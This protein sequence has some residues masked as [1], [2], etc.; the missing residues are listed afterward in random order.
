MIFWKLCKLFS[1]NDTFS[2]SPS[3]SHFGCFSPSLSLILPLS[4][5]SVWYH[6]A[7]SQE[8][9]H[10]LIISNSCHSSV[11]VSLCVMC[12]CERE[13]ERVRVC[14][15]FCVMD[16]HGHA[17]TSI[18]VSLTKQPA[19]QY[20]HTQGTRV[21]M[22]PIQIHKSTPCKCTWHL[23]TYT[24]FLCSVFFYVPWPSSFLSFWSLL[25]PLCLCPRLL[26]C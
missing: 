21:H 22:Q 19:N 10:E 1:P 18:T 5:P 11:F 15:L 24:V 13:R 4:V 7:F 14:K 3:F 23:Y 26:G 16:S 8:F 17:V 9:E 2:L 6:I 25:F 12:V 20:T